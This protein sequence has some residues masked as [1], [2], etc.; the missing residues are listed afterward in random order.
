MN[1][2]NI[3]ISAIVVLTIIA[4]LT[5]SITN[6]AKTA[7]NP[8]CTNNI[9]NSFCLFKFDKLSNHKQ[10][11]KEKINTAINSIVPSISVNPL[12][13]E[14]TKIIE[15]AKKTEPKIKPNET[16][17]DIEKIKQ[18]E[19]KSVEAIFAPTKSSK[20]ISNTIYPTSQQYWD[21]FQGFDFSGKMKQIY[22]SENHEF[23]DNSIIL[24]AKKELT[25]NPLYS[26]TID[27][28]RY[29]TKNADYAG[30]K[31]MLKQ[32]FHYGHISFQ[33]KIPN[34]SGI[35]P[36]VWL[37][38]QDANNFTEI[39]LLEVPGS[40]KNNVYGVTHYGPNYASLSSD[41]RKMNIPTLSTQFHK[42]DMYKTP[43]K[44]SVFI[45]GNLL[46]EKNVSNAIKYN[47]I[48]GLDQPLQLIINLNIGDS[49]AGTIDDS[50]LPV[51][52]TIK[53]IMIEE[54]SY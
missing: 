28:Q 1:F 8:L 47:G 39:D 26:T 51:S 41:H 20:T 27:D 54:Y 35:L 45:D 36:A 17:I 37:L 6:F 24:S 48:N 52:M 14:N 12:V 19:S 44:I 46:Y 34:I 43:E 9:N 10:E 31:L 7:F 2:K 32:K 33:A 16:K 13:A 42:Y 40:E 50:Q 11:S 25:Y 18:V 29:Y 4:G 30:S 49:W 53:D 23:R 15:E 5:I 21:I 22:N 38:N 3:L